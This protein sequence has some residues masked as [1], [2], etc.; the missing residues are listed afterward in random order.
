[1]LVFTDGSAGAPDLTALGNVVADYSDTGGGVV[2]ATFS[3]TSSLALSGR[4]TSA[5]YSVFSIGE[6][7]QDLRMQLV[8]DIPTSPLL[9]GVASFDGGSSSFHSAPVTTSPGATLIAHW[10]GDLQPLVAVRDAPVGDGLIVGLNFFPASSDAREDFW[11]AATDGTTLLANALTE[12]AGS[13]V[14]TNKADC[15][16]GGWRN[17]ANDQGHPFRNQGQ[18][19]SYVVSRRR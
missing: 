18:C 9:A 19:V 1:V 14:P 6:Q 5:G 7:A 11:D 16:N 17:L 4:M 12:S 3:F 10:S 8:P 15:K 13:A 2:V